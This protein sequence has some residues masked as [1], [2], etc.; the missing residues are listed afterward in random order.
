MV[1]CDC[2]T[3]ILRRIL[4]CLKNNNQGI[5]QSYISKTMHCDNDKTRIGLQFLIRLQLVEMVLK[6]GTR[7]YYLTRKGKQVKI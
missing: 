2:S 3:L 7:L 1:V 6:H 4:I 5:T